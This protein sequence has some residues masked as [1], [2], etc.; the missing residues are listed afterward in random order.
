[1][2]SLKLDK[3]AVLIDL[4]METTVGFL[5]IAFQYI[6]LAVQIYKYNILK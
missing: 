6:Y 4:F 2:K 5:S 3:N 1:M